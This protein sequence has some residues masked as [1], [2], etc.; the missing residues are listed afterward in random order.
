MNIKNSIIIGQRSGFENS[1]TST[2]DIDQSSLKLSIIEYS[3]FP[4]L[5][6]KN[7]APPVPMSPAP[8][9]LSDITSP[10]NPIKFSSC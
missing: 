2:A 9:I 1:K 8:I 10:R 7:D 4:P 6:I 3:F 5:C